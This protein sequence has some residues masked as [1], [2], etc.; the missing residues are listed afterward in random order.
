MKSIIT[1]QTEYITRRRAIDNSGTLFGLAKTMAVHAAREQMRRELLP[2]AIGPNAGQSLE[3][4]IGDAIDMYELEAVAAGDRDPAPH[5]AKCE[6]AIRPLGLWSVACNCAS[7]N[8]KFDDLGFDS[9]SKWA[10][11]TTQIETMLQRAW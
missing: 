8:P 3:Q 10:V 6:A 2:F 5:C 4:M 7:F 11:T 9:F 1:I